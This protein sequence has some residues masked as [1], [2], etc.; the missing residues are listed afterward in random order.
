MTSFTR[1]NI[2]KGAIAAAGAAAVVLPSAGTATAYAARP[3]GVALV[4]NRLTLPSGIAT[5][6]VTTDSGVLWS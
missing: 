5:G 1:R 2:L 6:D 3:S 4:R